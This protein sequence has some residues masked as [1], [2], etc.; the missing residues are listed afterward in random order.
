MLNW[1]DLA[2]A[3]AREPLFAAFEE[4]EAVRDVSDSD[5]ESSLGSVPRSPQTSDDSFLHTG[6][7]LWGKRGDHSRHSHSHSR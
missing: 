6:R 7:H 1:K 3:A 4:A 2:L 5:S